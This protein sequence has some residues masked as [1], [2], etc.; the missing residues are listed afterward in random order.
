[1][2][3]F[4]RAEITFGGAYTGAKQEFSRPVDFPEEGDDD[5]FEQDETGTFSWKRFRIV[6]SFSFPFLDD[7]GKKLTGDNNDE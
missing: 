2:L 4:R 5:I 7:I 3:T 1:M 6:F